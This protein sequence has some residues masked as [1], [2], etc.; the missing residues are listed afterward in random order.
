[1]KSVAIGHGLSLADKTKL[2]DLKVEI[3]NFQRS[4]SDGAGKLPKRF[5]YPKH[6]IEQ[7]V[8]LR[9]CGLTAAGLAISLGLSRSGVQCWLKS[10]SKRSSKKQSEKPL[11]ARE[12]VLRDVNDPEASD[13]IGRVL[14]RTGIILEIKVSSLTQDLVRCLNDDSQ[15]GYSPC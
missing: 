1:M 7:V 10:K 8:A 14:F 15:I 9:S 5:E 3:E 2:H 6:L 12:L 11:I 4:I 13:D